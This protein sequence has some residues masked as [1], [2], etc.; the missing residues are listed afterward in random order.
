[1]RLRE[2]V[3]RKVTFGQVYATLFRRLGIDVGQTTITDLNGRPQYLL[4]ESAGPPGQL[5]FSTTALPEK[6]QVRGWAGWFETQE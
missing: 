3:A 1:V 4:E 2:A 6:C 5:V